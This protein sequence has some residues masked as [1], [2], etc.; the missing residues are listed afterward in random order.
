MQKNQKKKT[1][2][3]QPQKTHT[4]KAMV[5][6]ESR[7]KAFLPLL[8]ILPVVFAAFYPILNNELTNWDDPDLIIDNPLIRDFSFEGVKKIF[9][10]F[11]FGNYQPLH[12]LAYILQ[13]IMQLAW[14]FFY[15]PL[16]WCI[17]LFTRSAG[18]TSPL[19]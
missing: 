12:L 14:F 13:D 10:T 9:S 4:K 16:R 17:I 15:S 5:S 8:F 11:Y 2:L 1:P 6:K 19:P 7:Y 18:R 3:V